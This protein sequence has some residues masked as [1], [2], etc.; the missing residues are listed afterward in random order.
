M[1]QTYQRLLSRY[2]MEQLSVSENNT[3]LLLLLSV[4][5]DDL[6]FGG[7]GGVINAEQRLEPT[8]ISGRKFYLLKCT[9]TEGSRHLLVDGA[10]ANSYME[11]SFI[12]DWKNH[13]GGIHF[14]FD[15]TN[16]F[17]HFTWNFIINSPKMFM[18][19]GAPLTQS[20]KFD[21]FFGGINSSTSTL[22]H[23]FICSLVE[24]EGD[25]I[26]CYALINAYINHRLRIM[27]RKHD[28]LQQKTKDT[29]KLDGIFFKTEKVV[30][31]FDAIDES[32]RVGLESVFYEF[33]DFSTPII[34][35]P[36]MQ[37]FIGQMPSVFR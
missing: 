31:F 4:D 35:T 19:F 2:P 30:K 14:K 28:K 26:L 15:G 23:R 16:T 5:D 21:I 24:F 34:Q 8:T 12:K 13:N 36:D 11:S 17:H 6:L 29:K 25:V 9:I 7:K 37:Q 1:T 32:C 20:Q 3:K 27:T 10:N 33:Q 18:F 22:H